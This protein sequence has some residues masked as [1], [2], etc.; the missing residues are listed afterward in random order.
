MTAP[1]LQDT[2]A[3]LN[4]LSQFFIKAENEIKN[5]KTVDMSSIDQ[6]V[7]DLCQ[8]VQNAIPEQQEVYLPELTALLNLL[9]SCELALRIMNISN[10]DAAPASKDTTHAGS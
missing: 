6:R 5:G 10:D 3:E 4:A 7:G 1:S 9:N 8:T 2:L